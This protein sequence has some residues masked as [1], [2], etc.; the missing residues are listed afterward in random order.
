MD[1][2]DIDG[3]S[4]AVQARYDSGQTPY[5]RYASAVSFLDLAEVNRSP[6]AWIPEGGNFLIF[7]ESDGV[8]VHVEGA[9][10]IEQAIVIA[11]A[12]K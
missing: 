3:T 7:E 2:Y 1:V 10:T 5:S 9:L 11:E 12:L 8:V 4:V 6:A